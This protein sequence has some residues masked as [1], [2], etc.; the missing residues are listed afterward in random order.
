MC[1]FWVLRALALSSTQNALRKPQFLGVRSCTRQRIHHTFLQC[2][3]P[4]EKQ[5]S[6]GFALSPKINLPACSLS[7]LWKCFENEM[8]H[9]EINGWESMRTTE[10]EACL[11]ISS[12][13]EHLL[14]RSAEHLSVSLFLEAP[15]SKKLSSACVLTRTAEEE[16][17]VKWINLMYGE[18]FCDSCNV[19]TIKTRQDAFQTPE[20]IKLN[21]WHIFY[22]AKN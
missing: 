13:A 10:G 2:W 11:Y 4:S 21:K 14:G 8:C 15:A 1:F 20:N 9:Y 19:F 6:S 5:S 17:F 16:V 12:V 22:F 3:E 7:R 18:H